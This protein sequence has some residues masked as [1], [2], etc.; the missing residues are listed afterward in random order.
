MEA[1][2]VYI[3]WMDKQ[4]VACTYNG[5]LFWLKKKGYSDNTTTDISEINQSQKDQ[6]YLHEECRVIKCIETESRTEVVRAWGKG[7]GN[8]SCLMVTG[9]QLNKMKKF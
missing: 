1:L 2:Q 8:G 5:I 7:G 4:N 6:G 3:R 9:F